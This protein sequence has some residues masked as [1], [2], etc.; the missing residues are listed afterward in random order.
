MPRRVALA[1]ADVERPP[2]AR[3]ALLAVDFDGTI[4][5]PGNLVSKRLIHR[6]IHLRR[7][8]TKLVLVTG[9][10]MSELE[11]L[12]DISL[13][14]AIVAENGTIVLID[15]KKKLLAPRSWG[16]VRAKLLRHFE[17]GCEEVVISLD[18]EQEARAS[19]V[20]KDIAKIEL[21]KNRIMI[22]PKGFDK[23]SGLAVAIE[24]LGAEGSVASIGDGENDLSMFRASDYRVA[25]E[26]SV[27]SLK[28]EAD[29]TATLPNGEGVIEAID[30]L[31][32]SN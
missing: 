14:D 27:D 24:G 32:S 9:R 20:V 26:N 8:G 10:C 3:P 22:M 6:L 17:R 11:Q 19:R 30:F 25:L 12:I 5:G 15:G 23:S 31:F 13:F 2:V 28:R 7:A 29:Y 1:G 4:K 21:N 16:P 18:R